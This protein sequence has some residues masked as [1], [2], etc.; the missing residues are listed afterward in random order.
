LSFKAPFI[1]RE[2]IW[3]RADQFRFDNWDER[4]PVDVLAI[5]EF[6]LGLDI[7]PMKYLKRDCDAEA[8]LLS[9]LRT[10]VVDESTFME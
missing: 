6:K 10:I 7:V 1:S 5:I 4:L 8:S 9:D 2:D 3:L